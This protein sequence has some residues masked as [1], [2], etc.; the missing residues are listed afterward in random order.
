MRARIVIAPDVNAKHGI[1]K[2]RVFEVLEEHKPRGP[3][4][5]TGYWVMGDAGKRVLLMKHE[6]ALVDDEAP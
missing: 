2:D 5:P 6:V 1:M 4:L 3:H